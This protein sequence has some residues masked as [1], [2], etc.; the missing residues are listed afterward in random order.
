MNKDVDEE[1]P[2]GE[3]ANETEQPNTYFQHDAILLKSI[4]KSVTFKIE[5]EE[6][7]D[8]NVDDLPT[9]AKT[10]ELPDDHHD[11]SEPPVKTT[12]KID[13][14]V[15]RHQIVPFRPAPPTTFSPSPG[16]ILVKW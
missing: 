5:K 1:E 12:W 2:E 8:E 3:Y 7:G 4:R 11:K 10:K 13:P 14:V 9:W 16:I 6:Q 15:H